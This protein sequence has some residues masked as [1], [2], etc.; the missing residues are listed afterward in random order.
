[1]YRG[2]Q[3]YGGIWMHWDIQIYGGVQ[4]YGV[5]RHM[6]ILECLDAWGVQL[7]GGC[8]DI[9]DIQMYGGVWMYGRHMDLGSTDTPRHT[10][11]QTYPQMLAK[12][13]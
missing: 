9:W 1:M 2:V 6:N 4:M 8:M 7:Y 10:D 11:S 12:Y 13:T 3:T 5:F